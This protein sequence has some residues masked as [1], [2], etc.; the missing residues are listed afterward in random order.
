MADKKLTEHTPKK[1]Y[2]TKKDLFYII[3]FLVF[4]LVLVFSWRAGGINILVNQISLVGSVSSILL[5]LIAIGYAFFQAN[6]S[7]WENKQMLDTLSRVNEKVEELGII[8]DEMVLIKNDISSF[9]E[10]SNDG[11]SNMM[12]AISELPNMLNFDGFSKL[13]KDQGVVIPSEIESGLKIKYQEKLN[14]EV[15]KLKNKVIRLDSELEAEIANYISVEKERNDHIRRIDV[16]GY[17]NRNGLN[18]SVSDISKVLRR[19][20]E[21][22]IVRREVIKNNSGRITVKYYKSGEMEVFEPLD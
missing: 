19:F 14:D 3:V 20:S 9:K 12:S 5:A 8:K 18:Y 7:S 21:V 11:M 16:K 4:A 15:N 22:G 10:V 6:N 13:L 1:E 2:I 17:L